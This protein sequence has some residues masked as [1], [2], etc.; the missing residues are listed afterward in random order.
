MSET[1]EAITAAGYTVSGI[2]DYVCV[3]AFRRFGS[4]IIIWICGTAACYAKRHWKHKGKAQSFFY[5]CFFII[6][7]YQWFVDADA[8]SENNLEDFYPSKTP[9]EFSNDY[10]TITLTDD[11]E[12]K[13]TVDYLFNYSSEYS[14]CFGMSFDFIND[15]LNIF[16]NPFRLVF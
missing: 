7:L 8:N 15:L 11:Y 2:D 13:E 1:K 16:Q 3:G 9:K 5:D 12:Q 14:L 4:F 6:R 10:L